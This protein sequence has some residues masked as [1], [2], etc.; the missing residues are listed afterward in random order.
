MAP[1]ALGIHFTPHTRLNSKSQH[2]L[3]TVIYWEKEKN[4]AKEKTNEKTYKYNFLP[5]TPFFL[6]RDGTRIRSYNCYAA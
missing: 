6:R 3:L 2:C 5:H 4:E 1:L